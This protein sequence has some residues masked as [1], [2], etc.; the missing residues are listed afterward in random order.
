M[1]NLVL[2]GPPGA[3]KGTQSATIVA[4]YNLVHLSTGNMLRAEI[5]SGSELGKRV[6]SIIDSGKLVSDAIVIEL[7]RNHLVQNPDAAGF[8]FDGF[9]RTVAQAEALDTLMQEQGSAITCMVSLH[10]HEEELVRRLL[11]R[12]KQ[13][14][15]TDD[16]EETIKARIREYEDKTLPVAK[17]YGEQ[18]KLFE[19]DGVGNVQEISTR[20]KEILD[21]FLTDR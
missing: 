15:R 2:F 4:N 6:K 9:P 16:T 1:L 3:G 14:G 20:I 21:S 17:Y 7:I 11:D 5:Q 12:G 18:D 8:I 19:V 10:V 13:S